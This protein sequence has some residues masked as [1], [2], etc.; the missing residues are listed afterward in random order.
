[1][2]PD[3]GLGMQREKYGPLPFYFSRLWGPL[4]RWWF[5]KIVWDVGDEES[6]W[7]ERYFTA[8]AVCTYPVGRPEKSLREG[9][10]VYWYLSC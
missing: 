6:Q 10:E 9:V 1:M 7:F 8:S 3:S 5:E 2:F 4:C